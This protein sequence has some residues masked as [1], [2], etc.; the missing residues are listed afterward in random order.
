MTN[1]CTIDLDATSGTHFLIAIPGKTG[2]HTVRVPM[3]LNGIRTLA[4]LLAD[5]QA[6]TVRP[7]ISESGALTG[8]QIEELVKSFTASGGT[9]TRPSDLRPA[10]DL[11][12]EL[13]DLTLNL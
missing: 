7:R 6:A 10:D 1:L 11:L 8:A 2:A 3:T 4:R 9:V 12:S 5:R 13:D